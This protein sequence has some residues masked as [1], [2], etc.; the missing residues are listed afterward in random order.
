MG[1]KISLRQ[2]YD[3]SD[4][5]PRS[6]TAYPRLLVLTGSPPGNDGV[7][8]ILQ[9]Q[10]LEEVPRE[11]LRIVTITQ[12]GLN[13]KPIANNKWVDANLTR[14]YE[15]AWR[16]INGILG[17][18]ASSVAHKALFQPH[19]KKLITECVRHGREHHSEALLAVLESPTV[20]FIAD[21]IARRLGIPLYCF[22]MDGPQLHSHDF[23]YGGRLR[24]RLLSAFD[25][26]MNYATRIGTAG[27]A[28]QQ[29]YRQAYGKECSILRQGV[30]YSPVDQFPDPPR[31]DEPLRI[32]FAGSLTARDAF[33][34]LIADLDRRCWKLAGREVILRIVGA[35][36]KLVPT[37]PQHI[38]Y[39]GWRSVPE[40]LDLMQACHFLYM[41]QPFSGHLQEFAELSFPNKL[42]TYVPARRPIMLHGPANASLHSFYR[43]YPCGPQSG[44][45][46]G[47]A[48]LEQTEH[49]IRD[50]ALYYVYQTTVDSAFKDQL[51]LERLRN[52]SNLFLRR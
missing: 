4:E 43:Q 17:D 24:K 40:M 36:L 14:R 49:A 46:S 28:M 5:F 26:C 37:G 35:H 1:S 30:Q 50:Q 2:Q 38:E 16:P 19:L 12:R 33:T 22:V 8:A 15:H 34:S 3:T 51:N 39:F 11:L 31:P 18:V 44:D 21:K 13:H 29:A 27:E 6:V 48:L 20:I 9:R 10:I 42:C 47:E 45:Q 32:G 52:Q 25:S 41:P 7:G 23:G